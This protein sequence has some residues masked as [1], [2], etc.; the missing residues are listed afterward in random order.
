MGEYFG[1]GG[2]TFSF[3]T[4]ASSLVVISLIYLFNKLKQKI[5]GL[6]ILYLMSF[7]TFTAYLVSV[8]TKNILLG[9]IIILIL[10]FSGRYIKVLIPSITKNI[11]DSSNRSTLI[12]T[13]SLLGSLFVISLNL[14][15]GQLGNVGDF[16]ILFI[17]FAG[18]ILSSILVSL[19]LKMKES[20]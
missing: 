17:V 3:L 8:L 1:Y 9:G 6:K 18:I 11:A 16:R 2:A 19:F 15:A 4:A 14:L 20:R 12:S 7:M 10:N 5:G 13:I